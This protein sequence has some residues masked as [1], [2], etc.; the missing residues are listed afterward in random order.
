MDEH[1]EHRVKAG[2]WMQV[3]V[4]GIEA[5]REDGAAIAALYPKPAG[6]VMNLETARLVA[7]LRDPVALLYNSGNLSREDCAAAADVIEALQA[8]CGRLIEAADAAVEQSLVDTT[9]AQELA[10]QVEA[11]AE[12]ARLLSEGDG[13]Q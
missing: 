7:A 10:A 8:R 4:S 5:M 12:F 3:S 13:N 9:W 11:Q 6:D 2:P 1:A